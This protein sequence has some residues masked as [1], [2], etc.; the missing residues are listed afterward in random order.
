[1]AETRQR[2]Y[3]FR[4]ILAG[5]DPVAGGQ[6]REKRVADRGHPAR[7]TSGRLSRLQVSHLLFQDGDR[8][9][10]IPAI[11]VTGGFALRDIKPLVHIFVA[12]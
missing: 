9:I 10:R 11:N 12:K 6:E 8:W 1:M 7:K 3:S 2:F 4:R 5:N